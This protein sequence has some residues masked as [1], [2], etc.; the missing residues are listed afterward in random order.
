MYVYE[1]KYVIDKHTRHRV[2]K[3]EEIERERE[4]VCKRYCEREREKRKESYFFDPCR[5]TGLDS[6]T[7]PLRLTQPME[8]YFVPW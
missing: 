4:N 6:W 1:E 5:Q 2:S 7:K 3:D 8:K